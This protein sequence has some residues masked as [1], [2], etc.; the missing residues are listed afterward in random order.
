[1]ILRSAKLKIR[2]ALALATAAASGLP[3]LAMD[4]PGSPARPTAPMPSWMPAPRSLASPTMR[5]GVPVF[6]E[7]GFAFAKDGV[8][9]RF[10]LEPESGFMTFQAEGTTLNLGGARGGVPAGNL[11]TPQ[12]GTRE[13]HLE[14]D[15]LTDAE[16]HSRLW[17]APGG[18]VFGRA[19]LGL[20][21]QLGETL[22]VN[23]ALQAGGD[24]AQRERACLVL[25]YC[26]QTEATSGIPTAAFLEAFIEAYRR[27][28]PEVPE[29]KGVGPSVPAP[30]SKEVKE[31][32]HAAAPVP[33]L[34]LD[35]F[36]VAGRPR[37]PRSPLWH[38]V[39]LSR[40]QARFDLNRLFPGLPTGVIPFS[41][42]APSCGTCFVGTRVPLGGEHRLLLLDASP[43]GL[44]SRPLRA[45]CRVEHPVKR[46]AQV[47]GGHALVGFDHGRFAVADVDHATPGLRVRDPFPPLAGLNAFHEFAIKPHGSPQAIIS[48]GDEVVV[49]DLSRFADAQRRPMGE[50]VSSVVW[51][52]WN[53]GVCPSVTMVNRGLVLFDVRRPL[54][55][56]VIFTADGWRQDC[57]AHNRISDF[58]FICGMADGTLVMGDLR[59]CHF[60]PEFMTPLS[61][62]PIDFIETQMCG[63]RRVAVAGLQGRLVLGVDLES[64]ATPVLEHGM[65]W[66]KCPQA[67][68]QWIQ[69]CFLP[70]G[71]LAELTG[72]GVFTVTRLP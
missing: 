47:D 30:E 13:F 44:L 19:I 66:L 15:P 72:D 45:S 22:L 62:G 56:A 48:A 25:G 5:N 55:E 40:S 70:T 18:H 57:W 26:A 24:T 39:G 29:W 51:P 9:W 64:K 4:P 20:M 28:L 32:A 43:E 59:T 1:M 38:H 2:T 33:T 10:E 53:A 36:I 63:S 52:F 49:A 3:A 50:F 37:P 42:P 21:R 7:G 60:F 11:L 67:I 34:P 35:A 8:S 6:H 41:P 12:G 16:A 61:I 27:T 71:E 23:V 14:G 68:P 58:H 65:S 17:D 31:T 46:V 69:P 54:A